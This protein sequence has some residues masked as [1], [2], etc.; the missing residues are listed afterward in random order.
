M[1]ASPSAAGALR[2]RLILAAAGVTLILA[3]LLV[4]VVQVVLERTSS[5]AV[6]R[7]LS[8]RA[9]AVV[10]DTGA[11][12][13]RLVVPVGELG[14]GTVVY[15]E[16]G[17]LV[18][19]TVPPAQQAEFGA[20]AGASRI[21]VRHDVGGYQ[22]LAVPFETSGGAERQRAVAGVVVVSESLTAYEDQERAALAVCVAA[23]LLL[24]L[25]TTACAAWASRRALA[26]VAAM[27]RTAEE[28]SSHHLDHRFGL[29]E[30]TDEIR[31]LGHTLDRLLDRV[32]QAITDEQ[33][34]TSELAHELRT[35]LTALQTTVELISYREDLDEE[36]R[37]DV[38]EL[39]ASCRTMGATITGLLDLARSHARSPGGADRRGQSQLLAVLAEAM[40]QV[41]DPSRIDLLTVPELTVGV[42]TDLAVRALGPVLENALRHGQRVAVHAHVVGSHVAVA[43]SDDGPGV[44][45]HVAEVIFDVGSTTHAGGSGLGLALAR[46]IARSVGGD[47][48]L[49]S[50]TGTQTDP[51][52]SGSGRGAT[53]TIL[54][55]T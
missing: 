7:V 16:G 22:L 46:R 45:P 30:P 42:P 55:P 17:T 36:L 37:A 26:P 10:A 14:P 27:A 38:A 39:M 33:R 32:A 50:G 9:A 41:E 24:V 31:A 8:D 44:A 6:D 13:G 53:F 1:P 29:G 19:G 18:A 3:V 52:A 35:P 11:L 25:L 21:Q 47:V 43:I 4:V 23:G 51:A 15:D 54:L 5:Q 2:R 28:W 48:L 34:L 49:E 12:D 40:R 20:L